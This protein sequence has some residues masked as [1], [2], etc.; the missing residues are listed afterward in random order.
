[1]SQSIDLLTQLR[2]WYDSQPNVT[3]DGISLEFTDPPFARAKRSAS[4]TAIGSTRLARLTVWETGEAELD[5]GDSATGEMDQ[6][7]REITGSLG[8]ADAVETMMAW[9]RGA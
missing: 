8:L 9:V 4:A 3:S 1:M 2:E 5:L 7:H 6:Q